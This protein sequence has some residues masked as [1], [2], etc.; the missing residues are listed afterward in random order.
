MIVNCIVEMNL[1]DKPPQ[2]VASEYTYLST[3]SP[4]ILYFNGKGL[5][6]IVKK[7]LNILKNGLY[8]YEM[9]NK[10]LYSVVPCFCF[11]FLKWWPFK[12]TKS[13]KP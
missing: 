4:I 10:T 6:H 1:R 5:H 3:E 12:K 2:Y 7:Y 9:R 8:Y 11:P 13:Q